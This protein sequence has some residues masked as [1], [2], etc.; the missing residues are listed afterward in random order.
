MNKMDTPFSRSRFNGFTF[1]RLSDFEVNLLLEPF[2]LTLDGDARRARFACAVSNDSIAR[3]CRRLDLK[4]VTVLGCVFRGKLIAA[5]ELH[6]FGSKCEMAFANTAQD[7]QTIFRQLLLL[8]VELA[9]IS[10]CRSLIVLSDP[11]EPEVVSILQEM[12]DLRVEAGTGCLELTRFAPKN[13][14]DFAPQAAYACL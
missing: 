2:Y 7:R 6:P 12:G 5:I 10:G 8:A 1:K 9:G 4:D 14:G 11:I 13:S 3:Y